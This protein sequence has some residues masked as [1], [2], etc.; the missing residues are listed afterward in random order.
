MSILNLS[1]LGKIFNT[2]SKKGSG[3]KSISE[4]MN[5]KLALDSLEARVLLSV[6]PNNASEL[7]VNTEYSTN[8]STY[9]NGNAISVDDD[10]DYVVTWTRGDNIYKDTT[11]GNVGWFTQDDELVFFTDRNFIDGNY[12]DDLGQ[13][14][15][16]ELVPYEDPYATVTPEVYY[17]DQDGN[18]GWTDDEGFHAYTAQEAAFR[19]YTIYVYEVDG[20]QYRDNVVYRDSDRFYYNVRVGQYYATGE[21]TADGEREII[22]EVTLT[23]KT[24]IPASA[25][26]VDY[27][28][29]GR[30]FTDE[31]QR[32]TIDTSGLGKSTGANDGE[33]LYKAELQV[34]EW[35]E[36]SITFSTCYNN[37]DPFNTSY[38][39]TYTY[40]SGEAKT[41]TF[42]FAELSEQGKDNALVNAKN[43]QA[44][45]EG[46]FGEG[47]VLVTPETTLKY[48]IKF[49]IEN[50]AEGSSVPEYQTA[51]QIACTD[52]DSGFGASVE[53]GNMPNAY[54]FYFE[55]VKVYNSRGVWTGEYQKELDEEGNWTGRYVVDGSATAAEI[56]TAFERG[57]Y[58]T[59]QKYMPVS[60]VSAPVMGMISGSFQ[61][62]T[63][64]VVPVYGLDTNKDL[65][66]F[67]ITFVNGSGK[68]NI[69]EIKINRI[70]TISEEYFPENRKDDVTDGWNMENTMSK[71]Y[72]DEMAKIEK[73]RKFKEEAEDIL[74]E[75]QDRITQVNT[76][77]DAYAESVDKIAEVQDF[78]AKVDKVNQVRDV[79]KQIELVT[80][81]EDEIALLDSELEIIASVQNL[82]DNAD[83]IDSI[84]TIE[85]NAADAQNAYNLF[86]PEALAGIADFENFGTAVESIPADQLEEVSKDDNKTVNKVIDQNIYITTYKDTSIFYENRD[87]GY[88]YLDNVPANTKVY[89]ATGENVSKSY[90]FYTN[91]NV[92]VYTDNVRNEKITIDNAQNASTYEDL[93]AKTTFKFD[94]DDSSWVYTEQLSNTSISESAGEKVYKSDQATVS[95]TDVAG[96][97]R[98]DFGDFAIIATIAGNVET[99]EIEG[100][101][102]T[103]TITNKGT[104]AEQK[105]YTDANTGVEIEVESDGTTKTYTDTVNNLTVTDN[106]NRT[107]TLEDGTAVLTFNRNTDTGSYTDE[108]RGL[109]FSITEKTIAGGQTERTFRNLDDK[110]SIST[111][112]VEAGDPKVFTI[113]KDNITFTV[114]TDT[115]SRFEYTA[116]NEEDSFSVDIEDF[117]WYKM[118]TFD[119][120]DIINVEDHEDDTLYENPYGIDFT[121]D[122]A[123]GEI[124][125]EDTLQ[126]ITFTIT[127]M[128]NA[129]IY[130]EDGSPLTFIVS[131]DPKSTTYRVAGENV[132][133]TVEKGSDSKIYTDTF[134][135]VRVTHNDDGSTT[136]DF[137]DG[138]TTIYSIIVSGYPGN[139]IYT[140]QR[141][142]EQITF[143]SENLSV[144]EELSGNE[145]V[146]QVI[147][148]EDGDVTTYYDQMENGV[149]QYIT[150]TIDEGT[151]ITTYWDALNGVEI[152]DD[153]NAGTL[154]YTGNGTTITVDT[155]EQS[156]T[157][158][159]GIREYVINE[160]NGEHSIADVVTLKESSEEFRINPTSDEVF[161]RKSKILRNTDQYESAVALDD[162]G[163]F[164]FSWTSE[165][166]GTTIKGSFT[167]VYTRLYSASMINAY[168]AATKSYVQI[169]DGKAYKPTTGAMMVNSKTSNPQQSSSIAMDDAGNVFVVW[170]ETAQTLSF[171]NGI[172][173]SALDWKGNRIDLRSLG[174][175]DNVT[176]D[177]LSIRVDMEPAGHAV[178]PQVAVSPDGKTVA[179]AWNWVNPNLPAEGE[180]RMSIFTYN[181]DE[182][183]NVTLNRTVEMYQVDANMARNVGYNSGLDNKHT[184]SST[185]YSY[186]NNASLQIN[187]AGQ[188]G[189][190][191]TGE[192]VDTL[193]MLT[194]DTYFSQFTLNN[195]G[196][197][198]LRNK[199]RINSASLDSAGATTWCWNHQNPTL[200]IDADGDF[201]VSYDGAGK[202]VSESISVRGLV[203]NLLQQKINEEQN[204]DL[205]P[206][207]NWYYMQNYTSYSDH[208]NPMK[209]F[210]WVDTAIQDFCARALK[211]QFEDP[212]DPMMIWNSAYDQN[213]N[214]VNGYYDNART[215][216]VVTENGDVIEGYRVA[217]ST[218]SNSVHVDFNYDEAVNVNAPAGIHKVYAGM[219][220]QVLRDGEIVELQR[221]ASP[222]DDGTIKTYTEYRN[223]TAEEG[224]PAV[225]RVNGAD[226]LVGVLDENGNELLLP[227]VI[228]PK[229]IVTKTKEPGQNG[230]QATEVETTTY[231]Y[232]FTEELNYKNAVDINDG[233]VTVQG[234]RA[235]GAVVTYTVLEKGF[236]V[237][238]VRVAV[239]S[240][241]DKNYGYD[242]SDRVSIRDAVSGVTYWGYLDE[243][244]NPVRVRVV[245]SD[246]V[247]EDLP[248]VARSSDRAFRPNYEWNDHASEVIG[249]DPAGNVLYG[250]KDVNGDDVTMTIMYVHEDAAGNMVYEEVTGLR[251][252]DP[253][254]E[255]TSDS[256][257]NLRDATP[258]IKVATQEQY[259]RFY[260][261]LHSVLD[262]TKGENT[263]VLYSSF[264]A[265]PIISP[266]TIAENPTVLTSDSIVNAMRDGEDA[267]YYVTLDRTS[268]FSENNN[269]GRHINGLTYAT[270]YL[271]DDNGNPVFD[272]NGRLIDKEAVNPD[273]LETYS[274]DEI[275]HRKLT[276]ILVC[277]PDNLDYGELGNSGLSPDQVMNI[278][279][280]VDLLGDMTDWRGN[281]IAAAYTRNNPYINAAAIAARIEHA[282]EQAI[283]ANYQD[284]LLWTENQG[285]S[286]GCVS[287]NVVSTAQARLYD[288]TVYDISQDND[289]YETYSADKQVFEIQFTGQ[290]HDAIGMV[291]VTYNSTP[292]D[293]YVISRSSYMVDLN[294]AEGWYTRFNIN[295]ELNEDV[296][297]DL[298]NINTIDGKYNAF[299]AALRTAAGNP[300][301]LTFER[302]NMVC[303]N[304]NN[305]YGYEYGQVYQVL[306]IKDTSVLN[307]DD[308]AFSFSLNTSNPDAN[309]NNNNNN[310]QDNQ[311]NV[312][313][314]PDW[315]TH[316]LAADIYQTSRGRDRGPQSFA[317]SQGSGGTSQAFSS[318]GMTPEGDFAFVWTQYNKDSNGMLRSQSIYTRT[319]NEIYDTYGPRVS[320]VYYSNSTGLQKITEGSTVQDLSSSDET[321]ALIVT[322][323]EDMMDYL[324]MD[325]RLED[326][327]KDRCEAHSVTNLANWVLVK[328][329]T[330]LTNAIKD[331]YFG[332]NA[333]ADPFIQDKGTITALCENKWEAVVILNDDVDLSTGNYQLQLNQVIQDANG[334]DLNSDGID[335]EGSNTTLNFDIL[336]GAQDVEDETPEPDYEGDQVLVDLDNTS[337]IWSPTALASDPEG[338]SVLVWTSKETGKEGIYAKVKY[339]KWDE[340]ISENRENDA[341]DEGEIVIQVT[342]DATAFAGSVDMSGDGNFVVTWTANSNDGYKGTYVY[343]KVFDLNG[344]AITDAFVVSKMKATSKWSQVAVSESGDFV[345]TWQTLDKTNGWDI[346]A[347][348]YDQD[349]KLLGTVDEVQV[350]NFSRDFSGSFQIRF[351][352]PD[353]YEVFTTDWVEFQKTY[354]SYRDIQKAL[355]DLEIPGLKFKVTA[356]SRT[357]IYV[358]IICDNSIMNPDIEQMEIVTSKTSKGSA[359]VTESIEGSRAPFQ[360]NQTTEGNQQYAAIDMDYKGNFVISWTSNAVD[361]ADAWDTDIYA[362]Q[363]KSSQEIGLLNGIIKS[364]VTEDFSN[365]MP[366]I[367]WMDDVD[368]P[369]STQSG[370]ALISV[371]ADPQTG[372]GWTGSGVLL[373]DGNCTYVLTA[374][375]C[376]NSQGI[377]SN[378]EN[379]TIQ[380]YN[381]AGAVVTAHV[382][383]VYLFNGYNPNNQVGDIALIKL[384][385]S[386]S[387]SVTGFGINREA[388]I[389]LGAVYTRY[390]FGTYGKG[391][392]GNVNDVD[393][394]MHTGQNRWEYVG[395]DGFL[396]FDF[397]DGTAENNTLPECI[398]AVYGDNINSDLGV[399]AT[400]TNSCKGDSGGPC[401][402]VVNGEPVVAG[403]CAGGFSE[404]SKYGDCS[405]DTQVAY[406]ADWIDSIIGVSDGATSGE[407]LVNTSKTGTQKWSDV[408]LDADGD[409]VITWTSTAS[410]SNTETDVYARRYSSDGTAFTDSDFK[411]NTYTG[412][413]QQLSKVAIDA[414]G[415]FVITWESYQEYGDGSSVGEAN[416]YGIYMQRYASNTEWSDRKSLYGPNGESG[417]EMRV[418]TT[419]FGNQRIPNVAMTATGDIFFAWQ[420]DETIE[421]QFT[422]SNDIYSRAIYKSVDDAGPVVVRI[423][424]EFTPTIIGIEG[425]LID[426]ERNPIL[427]DS[428]NPIYVNFLIED[429]GTY[430]QNEDYWFIDRDGYLVNEAMTVLKNGFIVGTNV[431]IDN[432]FMENGKLYLQGGSSYYDLNGNALAGKQ[433][434][435]TLLQNGKLVDSHG[436]VTNIKAEVAIQDGKVFIMTETVRKYYNADGNEIASA[437]PVDRLTDASNYLLD[438]NGNQVLVNDKPVL[439][440]KCW[441]AD[442]KVYLKNVEGYYL[443]REGK[444]SASKIAAETYSSDGK[445]IIN[446]KVSNITATVRCDDGKIY[447]EYIVKENLDRDGNVKDRIGVD[448]LVNISGLSE[449]TTIYG[450][451]NDGL[452]ITFDEQ[453]WGQH[454]N[455][456]Q[457]ISILSKSNIIIKLDGVN[458]TSQIV[459][460]IELANDARGIGF[461]NIDPSY[462]G[463]VDHH[464]EKDIYKIVFKDGVSLET[465]TYQITISDDV[466]DRFGN[467]LD[468]DSDGT[469]GGNYDLIFTV[470]ADLDDEGN[471]NSDI[472]DSGD[473]GKDSDSEVNAVSIAS[474]SDPSVAMN[475]WGDYVIVWVSEIPMPVQN[476]DD[477]NDDGSDNTNDGEDTRPWAGETVIMGQ[478][479]LR[480]GTKV[481]G[482]FCV[483]DYTSTIVRDGVTST[484]TLHLRGI[485]KTPAVA[486][487]DE[488]NFAVTWTVNGRDL[489]EDALVS[490]DEMAQYDVFVRT[491]NIDGEATSV[492]FLVDDSALLFRKS[493]NNGITTLPDYATPG[494]QKDSAIAYSRTDNTFVVTWTVDNSK[495]SGSGTYYWQNDKNGIYMARFKVAD[496]DDSSASES[497]ILPIYRQEIPQLVNNISTFSQIH[498]SVAVDGEENVVVV[499]ESDSSNT[500]L[501]IYL[502]KFE[503]TNTTDSGNYIS[504][505]SN[506]NGDLGTQT[507]VNQYTQDIQKLPDVAMNDEGDFVVAWASREKNNDY[508]IKF[509]TY[510]YK[511]NGTGTW[512]D[513]QK[514][515]TVTTFDQQ[516]PAVAITRNV[517]T[518]SRKEPNTSFSI[519]WTSYGQENQSEPSQGV[520]MIAYKSISDVDPVTN[521][522]RG[523]NNIRTK[524]GQEVLVNVY[525]PQDE[526]NPDI[527]MSWY[528]DIVTVWDGPSIAGIPDPVHNIEEIKALLAAH[529]HGSPANASEYDGMSATALIRLFNNTF[530]TS[531]F[532]SYLSSYDSNANL[533]QIL[534]DDDYVPLQV[535]GLDTFSSS[536]STQVQTGPSVSVENGRT[537]IYTEKNTTSDVV[538][539]LGNDKPTL[540]INGKAI[541]LANT[542]AYTFN[543]YNAGSAMVNVTVQGVGSENVS[544]SN[545]T[546]TISNGAYSF[547][548]KNINSVVVNSQN[549]NLNVNTRKGASFIV[550]GNMAHLTEKAAYFTINGCS[551]ITALGN[552][553]AVAKLTGTE[554]E[555]EFQVKAN[556]VTMNGRVSVSVKG[557]DKVTL[558]GSAQD[559]VFFRNVGN[560]TANGSVITVGGVEA[561]NFANVSV[562]SLSTG[563][564]NVTTSGTASV[565]VSGKTLTIVGDGFTQTY[566]GMNTLNLT[567]TENA[568]ATISGGSVVT[569][570]NGTLTAARY[571]VNAFGQIAVQNA[572]KVTLKGSEGDDT[573]TINAAGATFESA[574]SVVTF[575]TF[576]TLTLN[577]TEGNDAVSVQ[578]NVSSVIIQNGIAKI[579]D[580]ITLNGVST[581]AVA[582]ANAN[583]TAK[584]YGSSGNDEFTLAESVVSANIG[585]ASYTITGTSYI[586]IVGNEGDDVLT[587]TDTAGD[588]T[589]TLAPS[590][591]T[592]RGNNYIWSVSSVKNINL[593]QT[594][595]GNDTLNVNGS[596]TIDNAVISPQF[597]S[598]TNTAKETVS[599][600]GFK[601]LQVNNVEYLSMYDSEGDDAL[602]IAS[603]GQVTLESAGSYF[604][605]ISGFRKL[606]VYVSGDGEDTLDV[607][608]GIQAV[609]EVFSAKDNS[610][611]VEVNR[612]DF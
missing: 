323:T 548:V 452:Y 422:G 331:I 56:A 344:N 1:S 529:Y 332:M 570:D 194:I 110:I 342:D 519:V 575:N 516:S 538:I 37:E 604:N 386:F 447:F 32:F 44:S 495:D 205:L 189:I 358:T 229:T 371:I 392:E 148:D 298:R 113:K 34:G 107:Y 108:D 352:H 606:S 355:D 180:L 53:L 5:R 433:P 472:D 69:P 14:H 373:S 406:Y 525:K 431:K 581:L 450:K 407:F 158:R 552:S 490:A 305:D 339:L 384:T 78:E 249:V 435:V 109:N 114:I 131:Q 231:D 280:N 444:I 582:C 610:W 115:T 612:F 540:T 314:Y 418:N 569:C 99:Y 307:P 594:N 446:G 573:L 455:E 85:Q 399:G 214:P 494:T 587:V 154:T 528:G 172:Y 539:N 48:N 512:T 531:I 29:Y 4:K 94:A 303:D 103:L 67:D 143:E 572:A 203:L 443:D 488:G 183:K 23:R 254:D 91:T 304:A 46:I 308:E 475:K 391:S 277:Q 513:E 394:T 242:Y 170:A 545:G 530:G 106:G 186:D 596:R 169:N 388:G 400:E 329:G 136:Y 438:V 240:D 33:M 409:F 176:A 534:Q 565:N 574:G 555:E 470:V 547:T 609:D 526:L 425:E 50:P 150:V 160:K 415:D 457:P 241:S 269:Q 239:E 467:K 81:I 167:D 559:E 518:K 496:V 247:E 139:E 521:T 36:Q 297:L 218:D 608:A 41:A 261:I 138:N 432:M 256:E 165:T 190:A 368:E 451:I 370:V 553:S 515:N 395:D 498:S 414:D 469:P 248:L 523:E 598:V 57:E 350:L 208:D 568:S 137:L 607:A 121:V 173:M 442:G 272:A 101:G 222:T 348:R 504:G 340:S 192:G 426:S 338:D 522:I 93:A 374:Q 215:Y 508:D 484:Q 611:T 503:V 68:Q 436:N 310:N 468:G 55:Y 605:R 49:K 217:Q 291:G 147:I 445:L 359:A 258:A 157:Y 360:V 507:L 385:E 61:N 17:V 265:N 396:L 437:T 135:S 10:G 537:T 130:H 79:E 11:Y 458:V 492:P 199:Y 419:V 300:Q 294:H 184:P 448:S 520:Y 52:Q 430:L 588:D 118:Y 462:T 411:V 43:I 281:P 244:G 479:Y 60:V 404:D 505:Y 579:N 284:D 551:A 198:T 3:K 278:E 571:T 195:G 134:A 483:S 209:P 120:G 576:D 321:K 22:K 487:D 226:K 583:A 393:G 499:W 364:E 481:G 476:N 362:R 259:A 182:N 72:R 252:A 379:T 514:A 477:D 453:L 315:A 461:D 592:A 427:D 589:F 497:S 145:V 47:N 434:A 27:N 463:S 351:T 125:Y 563:V 132:A 454:A 546:F 71:A 75:A 245:N 558:N 54:Q 302:V 510:N 405:Y 460:H 403:I 233:I 578:S 296:V 347:Q 401:L 421:D 330:I 502:K 357:Q 279:V 299:E 230:G 255:G 288:D 365:S 478:R 119:N 601:N 112:E 82:E 31:V 471:V 390:G 334:R 335:I 87:T 146:S 586:T 603:N 456:R 197:V 318:V 177:G 556:E 486:M 274:F 424:G 122:K 39:L 343:A 105:T 564:G 38:D 25:Q 126:G 12:T 171:E 378:R 506:F 220:V 428:G 188:I 253:A 95:I 289:T 282:V 597:I 485:Q 92:Q 356:K 429:D 162:N 311:D 439:V 473:S 225:A 412:R 381:T 369:I 42:D 89:N 219:K 19:K 77:E 163:D 591:L 63:V 73:V 83:L 491:Y 585:D 511:G 66:G 602:T 84:T 376:V 70:Y 382:E 221:L 383:D 567:G 24:R 535:A 501:D 45:L 416:N 319:F 140:V 179:V 21:T 35:Y 290:F 408:A 174:L 257:F 9:T 65:V 86:K 517:T 333:S 387:G 292:D 202:D 207:I 200:A 7:L 361:S 13:T 263:G 402:I 398:A 293:P 128:E 100:E 449:N 204:A 124:V 193:G 74:D 275:V 235:A 228:Y 6:T 104:D 181:T 210:A 562:T 372:M 489:N 549:V 536:Y 286:Q 566:T 417:T 325:S 317:Y 354:T 90:I 533:A 97:R 117:G 561:S 30:Y 8:Q 64:N 96:S 223:L 88:T 320:D 493:G 336:T 500:S 413:Q 543:G 327:E 159:T 580:K 283:M 185:I 599:A 271:M 366:K 554:D 593:Y 322:F 341:L 367:T 2:S 557:F 213:G 236:E 62:Y 211:G 441:V 346:F 270:K 480:D 544:I 196:L 234:Y 18:E 509:R 76:Y 26:L 127:Q 111:V 28:V 440:D 250:Y 542:S 527:A 123:T 287:V 285:A 243:D 168:N 201:L 353:T 337:D 309:N 164:G 524:S 345:I 420:S 464:S 295:G 273:E 466:E 465:G 155:D 541:D 260:A 175:T 15:D 80:E 459:D 363:F 482:Q 102:I 212:N 142:T 40:P 276:I 187:K 141:G 156:T 267:K 58:A 349:G 133:I 51:F 375:H 227:Q 312:P 20:T 600:Y 238:R 268:F 380:F 166:L 161:N 224:G 16:I 474:Q 550:D 397:D 410:E 301:T 116:E 129:K 251:V 59:S 98:Y 178:M 377:I 144:Y 584:V 191:W 306:I 595:G 262:M 532:K 328:D 237:E 232:T 423:A 313:K 246:G 326:W 153:P 206:Y 389:E 266:G 316:T 560:F 264:D 577:D 324:K 149:G 216:R 151:G 590:S 152:E